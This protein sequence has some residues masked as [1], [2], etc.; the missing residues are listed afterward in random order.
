[1]KEWYVIGDAT[2]PNMVGGYENQ[3]FLDCKDDGFLEA[4]TTDVAVTVTLYNY[5]LSEFKEIRAIIQDNTADTQLTSMERSILVPIGTLKAGNYIYYENEYWLVDGRPGNN[6]IYE[7]ATLVECQYLLKWQNAKGEIIERWV[8]L[9]TASKYNIGE[10]GNSVITLT[11]NDFTVLIPD[12]DESFDIDGK[13]VFIDLHPT[14][15]TKVF[16]ITRADDALFHYGEQG[17]VLTLIADRT[18]FNS[19]TDNQEL[20]ICNYVDTDSSSTPDTSSP[21]DPTATNNVDAVISGNTSLKC[22][23]SRTYTVSFTDNDGNTVDWNDVNFDWNIESDFDSDLITRTISGNTIK[24]FVYA[25]GLIG[26]SFLLSV[27]VGNEIVAKITVNIV[28]GF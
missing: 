2:R 27:V 26:V 3:S 20:R 11:K 23:F 4:L 22:G 8:N 17:G 10:S 13:R 5:D 9:T 15:P 7:K 6:K 28:E 24:L 25:D 12:D 21:S 18:E 1:M 14:N 16:K 19:K